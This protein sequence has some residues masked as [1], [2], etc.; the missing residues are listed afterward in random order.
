VSD[1][2]IIDASA[3]LAYLLKEKGDDVVE[4]ALAGGVALVTAVNYCEVISTLCERGMPGDAAREAMADLQMSVVDFDTEL[5]HRAGVLRL[6]TVKIGA[7]LGDRACL[8]LADRLASEGNSP[9]VF[10]TEGAWT[11][12]KWAFSIVLIRGGRNA[13]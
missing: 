8:A 1:V 7:S 10:T 6:R 4:N 11:K 13:G 2:S 9:V 3:V 12:L 5:A